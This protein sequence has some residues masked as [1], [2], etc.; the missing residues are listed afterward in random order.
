M[1]SD[2]VKRHAGTHQGK[3][4][5]AFCMLPLHVASV[6]AAPII[7][8]SSDSS[9]ESV[10]YIAP[11]NPIVALEVGAVLVI[12]PTRV[13]DLVDYSYSSDSDPSENSFPSEQRPDRHESLKTSS[14][15]PLVPIV[16]PPKIHQRRV[17]H[18]HARRLVW[19]RVIHRS[20]DRHS[21]PDFT[22]DSSSSSL[23]LDSSSNISLDSSSDSLSDSSSFHSSGQSHSG[24]SIGV[25][26]PILFD[27]PVKTPRCSEAFMRWRSA[28][29]FTLYPPT[30]SDSSPN[31]SSER[32][33]DSSSPSTG[34]SRK[35]CRSPTTLVPSST[36]VTRSV[37]PANADLLPQ[38][39]AE[40]GI[41]KGVGA[42][43]ED[44]IDLGVEVATSD[45][46][47][48]EEDFKAEASNE[49]TMEIA[50]DPLATER[51]GLADRV[52][53]LGRENLRVRALLCIERDRVNNIRRHKA[54][55]QD[56]FRQVRRDRDYTG[57]RL[58]RTMIITRSGMTLEAIK[59]L[60]N[61]RVEEALAAYEATRATNAVEAKSRSQNDSDDDN[62]NG[63]NG[64]GG[65]GNLNEN[66]KGARP[67]ARECTYQDF[68]KCQPLNVKGTEGVVRLI[69]DYINAVVILATQRA[70]VVNPSV[71]TYFEYGR[72][73]HYKNE[74]PK[75][76][77]QNRR[78]Q[79]ANKNWNGEARGKSYVEETLTSVQTLS[80]V[81]I[82]YAVELADERVSK[83]NTILRGG[84]LGLLG[85]PFNIELMPVEIGSFD[86]I[87]G[88]DWLANHHAVSCETEDNSVEKRLE[89]VSTIRDFPKVFPEEL[90]GLP[91]TQKDKF[92]IHLI[93]GAAPVARAL[94]RLAPSKLENFVVYCNASCKGLGM[95][96]MQKE[97]VVAYASCQLKIHAKNYTTHDLELGAM[98][99]SL[100]IWRHYL[101]GTKC[102]VFT[103]HKS[104]QHILDQKE[105]NMR[106][107]RWLEL[108]SD[109]DCEI[110]YHLGKAN[111]VADALSRKERN[112]PLRVRALVIT[113][114]MNLP[115]KILNAQVLARNEEN[116]GTEDLY[117][118]IKK[119]ERRVNG[120]LCLNGR[121][122]IPCHGN[123]GEL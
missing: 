38:I 121:S 29:L 1:S 91:P 73:G 75:L 97:K 74:C 102:Y 111:M 17:G 41:S 47:E 45:I 99:F 48:E 59:E 67:V 19:R 32:L 13:L 87:I 94:Y 20:L 77:N 71:P 66:D 25:A 70:L 52:T 90:H 123:L 105:L 40:L 114:C 56:E 120:T 62:G 10:V 23:S 100:K 57:R 15:F 106:Q 103:D 88:M 76:M 109:Y 42:Y 98:V 36:L 89:Y 6:M 78:N 117:D 104:L 43:T 4:I 54:L 9:E 33:L 21:L 113:I 37:A 118:M 81:R 34:P 60:V 101:Y 16:A 18:F 14:K 69:R 72:K 11:A 49:G 122:W 28:P 53:S 80:R 3:F 82:S 107:R 110:C 30:T 65:N 85:H 115:V 58:K 108:L 22:S 68:I 63:R 96:L 2:T 93:L 44:G 24:P 12:S 61:R 116:Y 39:V 112:K 86:V 5:K 84:T 27:L 55:S 92:Q 46:I 26:S 83:T 119:L 50:I 8:I 64:N 79:T 7:S 51:V 35:R 95:V 31:L